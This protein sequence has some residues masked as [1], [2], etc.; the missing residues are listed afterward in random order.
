MTVRLS[1]RAKRMNIACVGTNNFL[2]MLLFFLFSSRVEVHVV[3]VQNVLNI[4]TR[5]VRFYG[6]S[7]SYLQGTNGDG[8]SVK[9]MTIIIILN[10]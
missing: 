1:E 6:L 10:S 8:S 4:Y 5:S 7:H 9:I 3:R 2:L